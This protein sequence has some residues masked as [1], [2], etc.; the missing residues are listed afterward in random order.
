MYDKAMT[1]PYRPGIKILSYEYIG[2]Y[3]WKNNLMRASKIANNAICN[4]FLHFLWSNILIGHSQ[5]IYS[6]VS[7]HHSCPQR[8]WCVNIIQL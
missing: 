3:K 8:S 5:D 4:V 2:V 1:M 6:L 7:I